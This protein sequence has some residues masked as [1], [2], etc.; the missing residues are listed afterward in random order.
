MTNPFA[1][2][3]LG[4]LG[5]VPTNQYYQAQQ[6]YNPNQQYSAQQAQQAQAFAQYAQ[7][8]IERRDWRI[9]GQDM[10]LREFA[11]TLWPEDCA[12]KTMFFLKYSK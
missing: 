1:Q 8:Q 7:Q 3:G 6:A 10:T 11:D 2:I 12:D 5:S 4:L 9:N